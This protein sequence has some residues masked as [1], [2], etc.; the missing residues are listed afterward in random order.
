MIVW[1]IC[2]ALWLAV[3][4]FCRFVDGLYGDK[5]PFLIIVLWPITF[6]IGIVC[7]WV[8]RLVDHLKSPIGNFFRRIRNVP[9]PLV[10]CP[11][12]FGRWYGER[13]ESSADNTTTINE[14][15]KE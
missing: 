8:L 2:I 1:S 4:Y 10:F 7:F 3:I 12:K 11:Y 6:P 14:E 15:T 5:S 13:M 9:I